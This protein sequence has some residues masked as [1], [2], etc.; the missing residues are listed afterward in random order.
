M[1]LCYLR[2][3]ILSIQKDNLYSPLTKF[4][5]KRNIKSLAKKLYILK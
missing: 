4:L 2:L 1:W 5:N 3:K